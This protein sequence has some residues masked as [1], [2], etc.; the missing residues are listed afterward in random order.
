[1]T[2]ENILHLVD[3]ICCCAILF[4]IVWQVRALEEAVAADE[5]AERT[6]KKLT[7]F[8]QFYVLVVSYIYFTRIIVYL[9]AT[10]L[11]YNDTWL[12]AFFSEGATLVFY[13][14]VGYKFRPQAR[15]PYLALRGYDGEDGEGAGGADAALEEEGGGM[16]GGVSMR[17]LNAD[18][19]GLPD[20]DELEEGGGDKL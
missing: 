17:T 19:F 11:S 4:P 9:I 3:I 8:R 15:N 5:K 13:T 7:L 14:T 18:E 12:Q 16:V 10:M 1:M 6:I 20:D 2:W